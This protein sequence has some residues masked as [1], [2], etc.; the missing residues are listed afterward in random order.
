M[1]LRWAYLVT[2]QEVVRNDSGEIVELHCSY[3]PATRGGDTPDGRR[4][5]GTLHWVSA[6]HS[7]S[8]RVRL[9]DR[10]FV[11]ERPGAGGGDFLE[12]LNPESLVELD[13]CRAE[14]ELGRVQAG[15]RFQFERQGYFCVDEKDSQPG[16]PVFNRIVPLR[17]SWAKLVRRG[18]A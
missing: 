3:D 17:D 1:R 10:L 5:K 14:P 11:T 13:G 7:V 4:V 9:Y 12:D 18:K 6:A 2:C 16:R 15:E 8:C